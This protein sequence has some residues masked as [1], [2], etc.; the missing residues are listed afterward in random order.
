MNSPS[1]IKRFIN[2]VA[3][4]AG[5]GAGAAFVLPAAQVSAQDGATATRQADGQGRAGRQHRRGRRGHHGRGMMHGFR[6]LNLTDNQKAQVEAIMEAAREQ[7]RELRQNEGA[8]EQMHALHEETQRLLMDVLTPAQKTQLE[9]LREQHQ[10]QH[11]DRRVNRM[12]EKLSLSDAQVTRIRSIFEAAQTQRQA[13]RN[14]SDASDRR[15][16]MQALRERTKAA[17]SA[18]L[19]AEQRTALEVMHAERGERGE[20]G[21]HGR[22]GPRGE[23]GQGQARQAR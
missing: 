17:V 15:E 8:R 14:G 20:R 16:A 23:R 7:R 22:R 18:V 10:T 12:K 21:R 1:Q 3:L 19:T 11:L 13:L 2:R 5:L 9:Q 6:E 4:V